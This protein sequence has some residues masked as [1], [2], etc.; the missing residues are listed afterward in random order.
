MHPTAQ[1]GK[2]A[3]DGI[4]QLKEELIARGPEQAAQPFPRGLSTEEP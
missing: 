1:T 2:A 3:Q 4:C